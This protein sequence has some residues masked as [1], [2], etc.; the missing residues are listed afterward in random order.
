MEMLTVIWNKNIHWIKTESQITNFFVFD[1]ETN[2]TNRARP[3]CVSLYGFK[4][5][6][7]IYNRDLQ[8]EFY[9]NCKI[10]NIVSDE[11]S[12]ITKK[13]VFLLKLKTDPRKVNKH[14]GWMKNSIACS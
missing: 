6:A 5:V 8:P 9:Q 14:S 2:I 11:E 7:S 13:I 10:D 12:C 4:K 1:L 3:Y